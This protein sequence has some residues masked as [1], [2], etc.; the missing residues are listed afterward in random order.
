M[1]STAHHSDYAVSHHTKV[2]STN[3]PEMIVIIIASSLRRSRMI[4]IIPTIRQVRM[5]KITSSPAR[6]A[7][8]LPQPDLITIIAHIVADAMPSRIA[9]IIPK[10]I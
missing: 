4:P 1:F 7:R 10:H 6:A 8:G 9:E 2:K 3:P 5:E